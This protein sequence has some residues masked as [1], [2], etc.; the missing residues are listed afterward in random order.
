MKLRMVS[1][2]Q[3][4]GTCVK[5]AG[6]HCPAGFVAGGRPRKHDA[7]PRVC[8]LFWAD[9]GLVPLEVSE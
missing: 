2:V 4:V 6:A 7:H 8:N 1:K 5:A 3:A 9:G